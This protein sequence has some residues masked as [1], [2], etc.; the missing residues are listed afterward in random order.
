M[1]ISVLFAHLPHLYKSA[2]FKC[3]NLMVGA[4]LSLQKK[5][6]VKFRAQ[7]FEFSESS[8]GKYVGMAFENPNLQKSAHRK[9]QQM[10]RLLASG[11]IC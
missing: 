11:L 6:K 9:N 1:R 3:T 2:G 10:C 8:L 4:H 7:N 5:N